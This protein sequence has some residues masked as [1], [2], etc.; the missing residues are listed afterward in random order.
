MG[1][2]EKNRRGFFRFWR[3]GEKSD[4]SMMTESCRLPEILTTQ[5]ATSGFF[6]FRGT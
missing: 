5:P 2:R 3:G 1:F 6:L 4:D